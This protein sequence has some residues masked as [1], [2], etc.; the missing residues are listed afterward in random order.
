MRFDSRGLVS[1]YL[2]GWMPSGDET[3]QSVAGY[4]GGGYYTSVLS[5]IDK[6]AFP[7]DSKS[8]LSATLSVGTWYGQGFADSGVAGYSVSGIDSTNSYLTTSDKIAFPADT[9]TTSAGIIISFLLD[10]FDKVTMFLYTKYPPAPTM[11]KF[12]IVFIFLFLIK[13]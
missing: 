13:V 7:N 12:T 3:R 5:R 4:F 9:K 2:S 8:T 6:I 10:V 11:P 1:T